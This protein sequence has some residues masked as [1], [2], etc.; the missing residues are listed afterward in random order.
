MTKQ[1]QMEALTTDHI[2]ARDLNPDGMVL[3]VIGEERDLEIEL[4]DIDRGTIG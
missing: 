3:K 2:E 4:I 1:M